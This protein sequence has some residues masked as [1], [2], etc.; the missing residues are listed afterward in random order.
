MPCNFYT[1][2]PKC[3][4]CALVPSVPPQPTPRAKR[5]ART[6]VRRPAAARVGGGSLPAP[7]GAGALPRRVLTVVPRGTV[8]AVEHS[9]RSEA[10][11]TYPP[12]PKIVTPVGRHHLC[13]DDPG[14]PKI[15]TPVGRYPQCRDDLGGALPAA[16]HA[17]GVSKRPPSRAA[18][19]DAPDGGSST[20][21]VPTSSA[22]L[23]SVH[24]TL[25]QGSQ[26]ATPKGDRE[27]Q[28]LTVSRQPTRGSTSST[29]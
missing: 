19:R 26:A 27:G 7:P 12:G 15:V 22:A 20:P 29:S 11:R 10:G 28:R 2:M 23:R 9:R 13:R 21:R 8:H 5:R 3:A 17:P 6:P 24:R 4:S 14:G 25:R 1:Q 16:G 18:A